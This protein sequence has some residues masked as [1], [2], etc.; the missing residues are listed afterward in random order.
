MTYRIKVS[1]PIV[2]LTLLFIFVLGME[3]GFLL[4]FRKAENRFQHIR[5]SLEETATWE[6]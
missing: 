6:P 1:K 2:L 3:L 5:Q 4:D